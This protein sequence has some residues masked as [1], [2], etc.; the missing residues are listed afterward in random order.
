MTVKEKRK[1]LLHM[2]D[3]AMIGRILAFPDRERLNRDEE[4]GRR[5]YP[6]A[7][8]AVRARQSMEKDPEWKL[9]DKQKWAMAS[10]FA[11][12]SSDELKVSGITFAKADP[13]SLA[14]EQ[15]SKEGVKAVY[16]MSFHLEPEPENVHDRNAVA[17][18]VDDAADGGRTKIGYVPAAYVA[19]HPITEPMDVEGTLTDHSNG[20]FK[21]ISYAMDMDTE[22]VCRKM[23]AS[24][25]PGAYTYRMPFVL[26]GNV[27]EGAAE[28]LNEQYWSQDSW[29][30]K[31]N[32]E[33][34]YWGVNGEVDSVS[35]SF[36]GAKAGCI[37][38]ESSRE[39]D[40]EAMQ[41]CGS[42]FRYGLEAGI[43]SGLKR[44]RYVDVPVNRPAVDLKE[45]TYFS[46]QPGFTESVGAVREDGAQEL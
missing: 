29:K 18:Y 41:V 7:E 28:Y 38:V 31:L 8:M 46:L 45:K 24:L 10:S 2:D 44:G 27:K 11:E 12:H 13:N 16:A 36:P 25:T 9:S 26:N 39:L 40:G 4:G 15:L 43:G 42:Y 21:T 5:R 35:F 33:L 32:S 17:V 37:T 19:T 20:R 3:R 14:K 23:Q 6:S 30:D 22:A 34:E 1:E